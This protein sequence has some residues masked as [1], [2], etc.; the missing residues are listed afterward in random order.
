MVVDSNRCT[1]CEVC[2][3]VC[4]MA[5]YDVFNPEYSRIHRVRIDPILNTSLACLRCKDAPCV[6]AC[7]TEALSQNPET[8]TIEIVDEKCNACGSCVRACPF[9]VITIHPDERK[10]IS[11][12]LCVSTQEN[13][14]QCIR[15]CPKSAIYLKEIDP[16]KDEDRFTTLSRI[17]KDG[18]PES[19]EGFLNNMREKYREYT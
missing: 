17:I 4:S 10:A 6:D 13:S 5:H 9:G 2:E 15:Y 14:P 7:P 18:F 8:G 3:S 12:D 16:N 11:C 1:G 19:K